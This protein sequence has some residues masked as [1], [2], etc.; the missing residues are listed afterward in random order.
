MK[1]SGDIASLFRKH[2][3]KKADLRLNMLFN[4]CGF[5]ELM[6]EFKA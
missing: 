1:R 2:E 4:V 5:T 6:F 3:A